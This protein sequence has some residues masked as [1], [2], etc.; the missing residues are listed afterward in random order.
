MTLDRL[1][2]VIRLGDAERVREVLSG[3]DVGRLKI[4]PVS[5][6]AADAKGRPALI[7]AVRTR[8]V[9]SSVVETLLEFGADPNLPD[10]DGHTALDYA[11]RRLERLGPGPDKVRRSSSLDPHGNLKL[12]QYEQEMVDEIAATACNAEAAAEM[13]DLY[14]QERR[15]VALRQWMPRR[16]RTII[17]RRLEQWPPTALDT[18][19]PAGRRS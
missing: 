17:I 4:P 8:M 12:A 2:R 19:A 1:F 18:A 14:I 9:E 5:A 3:M 13:T 10:D 15:K 16:E 6:N 7:V 11:R